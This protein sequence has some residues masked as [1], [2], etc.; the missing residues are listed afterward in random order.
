MLTYCQDSLPWRG[1]EEVS[2]WMT[3]LPEDP[4]CSLQDTLTSNQTLTTTLKASWVLLEPVF[5]EK[6]IAKKKEKKHCSIFLYPSFA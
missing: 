3:L 5:K 4:L 6:V 2:Y 1:S